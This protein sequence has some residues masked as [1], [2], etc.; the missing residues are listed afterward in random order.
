MEM[1]LPWP[2][3]LAKNQA[4]HLSEHIE[5]T[6]KQLHRNMNSIKVNKS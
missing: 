2:T 1:E 3:V 5:I 4:N 6:L